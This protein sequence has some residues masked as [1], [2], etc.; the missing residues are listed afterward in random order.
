MK[1]FL[2]FLCFFFVFDISAQNYKIQFVKKTPLNADKFYGVDIF[3]NSYYSQKNILFKK[4]PRITYQYH[5]LTL[6]NIYNISIYNPLKIVVFYKDFNTVVILDNTLNEIQKLQFLNKNITLVA[7]AGENELWLYNADEQQLELY[8]Y[9]TK[10]IIGKTQPYSILNPLQLK[11]NAN[12]AWIQTKSNKLEVY[13]NYGSLVKSYK[14]EFSNFNIL[15]NNRILFNKDNSFY[16]SDNKKLSTNLKIPFKINSVTMANNKIFL[17]SDM[18]IFL[19]K[20]LKI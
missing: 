5:N 14:L 17:F 2:T 7:K 12:Y 15:S 10:S 1:Y 3:D 9:K 4:T 19:F 8:N 20:L 16:F 11:G 13:N 18:Q 6:G